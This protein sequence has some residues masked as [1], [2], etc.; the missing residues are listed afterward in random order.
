[1]RDQIIII[2]FEIT[3]DITNVRGYGS[4]LCRVQL[5]K[6]HSI[7]GSLHYETQF[8]NQWFSD[9]KTQLQYTWIESMYLGLMI[10]C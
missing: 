1:M 6:L 8:S 10:V 7:K 4:H 9:H 5:V 3:H 2:K